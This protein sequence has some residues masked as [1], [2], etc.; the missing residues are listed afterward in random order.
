MMNFE[1]V[2]QILDFAI[3]NEETAAEFYANLASKMDRPYM[4]K[5]FEE[6][7][8]EE[9]GHKAKLLAVQ[10]GKLMVGSEKK[11]ID[12]K[13][14]DSLVEIDLDSNLNYQDALIVAMKAEKAAYKLYN[15]LASSTDDANLKATLLDLAQEEAKH[16]LRFEIEYDEFV[17]TEN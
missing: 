10:K 11:I 12:L 6:F 5:V 2:D 13:L 8:M 4:K 14:G 1:S 7:A 15:D 3:K 16:K 9:K 17:L